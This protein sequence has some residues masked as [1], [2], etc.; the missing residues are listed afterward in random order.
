M[1]RL[2]AQCAGL[3][4]GAMFFVPLK[5][6]AWDYEV[7]RFI[8]QLA[9]AS[10]PTNFP[11]FVQTPA[12]RERIAFLGGEPD[13]WRNTPEL[14]LRH[15]NGP[16]HYFDVEDLARYG[17]RPASLSPF[18]Y[19]FVA[20]LTRGRLQHPRSFSGA[21]MEKDPDR[22]RLLVGF[23]PWTIAEH[24][25]KL[26]SGF[27]YLREFE[28]AGTPEEVANAQEN[29]LSLM[30]VMGHFVGDAT[31]PL[32]TTKHFNGWVG[33]NPHGYTTNRGFHAWID[34]GFLR[35]AGVRTNAVLARIRT[36][37]APWEE[38]RHNSAPDPFGRSL[39]FVLEQFQLV[40]P[41]YR[42]EKNGHLAENDS[43]IE[44][45]RAFLSDQLLKAGQMLGDLWFAAWKEAPRD[46]FLQN[47]LAER[48]QASSATEH[49]PR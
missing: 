11:A 12:A 37:R 40:E 31:Q 29:I 36:A 7:H 18:R 45:G 10:L 34:G 39:A 44:T 8:N 27:S 49:T 24:Y 5:A 26:K 22:T 41:L 20:Q 48:K 21:D 47:R 25:S 6:A 14:I 28:A 32:H 30:G 9:L 19:E 17:L 1:K 4:A 2:L 23:L 35:H 46:A 13:R 33:P 42:L 38:P 15:H 43:E 3:A 16:D